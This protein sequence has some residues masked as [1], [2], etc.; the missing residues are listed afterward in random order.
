MSIFDEYNKDIDLYLPKHTNNAHIMFLNGELL[1]MG[2]DYSMV[3]QVVDG[4]EYG[5]VLW[6]KLPPLNS[7]IE[8][9]HFGYNFPL[10]KAMEYIPN[11]Y[12]IVKLDEILYPFDIR[13]ISVYVDGD[14]LD[15]SQVKR[16]SDRYIKIRNI[17][18]NKNLVI[19]PSITKS[20]NVFMN[21]IYM[22]LSKKS[23]LDSYLDDLYEESI[24]KVEEFYLK[25]IIDRKAEEIP[26]PSTEDRISPLTS[27]ISLLFRDGEFTRYLN[28]NEDINYLFSKYPVFKYFIVELQKIK[29]IQLDCNKDLNTLIKI[30]PTGTQYTKDQ[31]IEIA[32]NKFNE[33]EINTIDANIDINE[34]IKD[35]SI[36]EFLYPEEF[37]Q[38]DMSEIIELSNDISIYDAN[39]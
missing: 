5:M 18:T 37:C 10:I 32:T 4:L 28:A 8:V 7:T 19:L 16:L 20:I 21:F 24:T 6:N 9:Y 11:K 30:D 1:L 15:D 34:V 13:Y 2:I 12:G 14:L 22:F 3:N 17:K 23:K 27:Y 33:L 26:M 31:V 36:E 39:N 29:E 38:I 35:T 25:D